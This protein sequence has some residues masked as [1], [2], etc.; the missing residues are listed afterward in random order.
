ME[1]T[2][3]ITINESSPA[4]LNLL[5]ALKARARHGFRCTAA[6]RRRA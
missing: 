5:A 1:I 3:T 2:I 4:L 6:G